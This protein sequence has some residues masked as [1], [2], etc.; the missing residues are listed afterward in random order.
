MSLDALKS[1]LPD[2]AKD[3]KLNLGGVLTP[4]HLSEVQVWG[5]ALLE[6]PFCHARFAN[7]GVC[8]GEDFKTGMPVESVAHSART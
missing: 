7:L 2:Y 6:R 5:T 1:R 4:G 3:I 8:G